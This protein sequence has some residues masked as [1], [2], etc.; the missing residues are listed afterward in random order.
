MSNKT[1]TLYLQ[2]KV[3]LTLILLISSFVL[4]SYLILRMT[5]APAFSKL[6]LAA[7]TSDFHRAEGALQTDIE[8][9]DAI[10]ADWAPWD[11]IH[12][13]TSG[14]NPGFTKSNLNR[15]T[16][17][18][19]SLD[20]MAIYGS[21]RQ[22]LWAMTIVDGEEV[23][24]HQFNILNPEHPASADIVSHNDALDGALGIVRTINGLM[25]ISSRPIL[26]SDDSGPVGGAVVMGQLL[27]E[28]HLQ[29]LRDRTEVDISLNSVVPDT[30]L[31]FDEKHDL[32]DNRITVSKSL[33]DIH[34]A[35]VLI[36]NTNTLRNISN[37]GAQTIDAALYLLLT[38]GLFVCA[39]IWFMLRTMI[40]RPIE[41]LSTHI[42]DIR[43]SGDLSRKL[44]M[45]RND[46]IGLLASQFDT[47]TT[48]VHNARQALLDQSFKAGKADTAA[49][50]MHNIRNAMTPMINGIDRIKRSFKV[51]DSLRVS[52]AL[53]QLEEP[54][55]VPDRKEKLLQYIDASFNR[56]DTVSK[57]ALD[58]LH[59]VAAQAKQVE[60]I[61][62]DQEKFANVA[63]VAEDLA[64][65]ELLDE[66]LHVIPKE[67]SQLVELALDDIGEVR[68][69]AHRIG[70]LQVM[71][72]V[73]LNAY[74][75]IR[76]NNSPHG[77]ISLAVSGEVVNDKA[78]VRLTVRD[79]G[80]GFSEDTGLQIFNRGFTSKPSRET[81]GLGLHWC[82][83]AVASM[84][85]KI[86]AR[87]PGEGCGA[88]FDVMLPAPEG[89]YS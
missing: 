8:N 59:I 78:M 6:E 63:P 50:V 51:T 42:D 57:G 7:A 47:L 45:S 41:D 20:L 38:S 29:R 44:S 36:F 71:G 17:D 81:N 84:G 75:S 46:E 14:T 11:D 56:I 22:L 87:S 1:R 5:I 39:F 64:V 52:E 9:L 28:A 68:V 69:S 65:K 88:E 3:S 24:T 27:D 79:N 66:A 23:P 54:N 15:P 35:P 83:N 61:I 89:G 4:I 43:E 53:Q 58:D 10:T 86:S 49:E 2:S 12:D 34:G 73:I 72:N 32:S 21:D 74:E 40:L 76:R 67:D 82:A 31:S 60:G 30:L 62:A 55:C 37:L 33:L 25:L 80:G 48:E 26:R 16:L 19:L 13:Y 85:G 70:L 18:N 77:K